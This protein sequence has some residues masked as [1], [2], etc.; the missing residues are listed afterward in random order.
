MCIAN[1][2][3]SGAVTF[4]DWRPVGAIEYGYVAPD[5]LDPDV[6]FGAGRNVVTRYRYST[7]QTENVSPIPVL[8]D[9]YRVNRTQ[10][11]LFSAAD[12]HVL[13]YAANVVFETRDGGAT[14]RAI[15]PDLAGEKPGIPASLGTLADDDP[16]AAKKRGAVYALGPSFH[17]T[18]TLWAG[19]DDGLIHVTRDGGESWQDVTPDGLTPWS[20]V[21]QIEASH[22][23]DESAYASVSRLRV[24]D[25]A[26]Y[27]YRTHDGGASWQLV[28]GRAAGGRVRSTRCAR[29]PVRQGLLYAGTET[30][31]WVSFDDGDHWQSLQM[32]LPHSSMRDLWIH[33]DDLIV[34]THGRG[35]WILDDLAP[36]RQANAAVA[37]AAMHLFAPTPAVR[38]RRSL[39]TD[40]PLPADE[41]M[42]ENPPAGA[43]IDYV[44]GSAATRP[45]DPRD[46][47]RRRRAGAP[48]RQH[49]RAGAHRRG[50]RGADDPHLLGA[51]VAQP[52]ATPG[53]HRWVWDLRYAPPRGRRARLPDQRRAPRHAAGAAGSA[54]RAGN[55]HGAP[56]GGRRD[57]ATAPL[58]VTMDPRVPTSAR[59]PRRAARGRAHAGQAALRGHRGDALGAGGPRAARGA[60]RSRRRGGLARDLDGA[61]RAGDRRPS[62]A[63]RRRTPRPAAPG[64]ETLAGRVASL[65]DDVGQADVAPTAAQARGGGP[66]RPRPRRRARPLAE[67]RR[68]A[69]TA[70]PQAAGPR[71]RPRRPGQGPTATSPTATRSDAG[72]APPR[73]RPEQYL[74]AVVETHAGPQQQRRR[75]PGHRRS[76]AAGSAGSSESSSASRIAR[77]LP[78][79][80]TA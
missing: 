62:K 43:V 30:G 75:A 73:L 32:N 26:P 16:A 58:E 63:A 23:D 67:P 8:G 27:V 42:G 19:T 10:P 34:A 17:T 56:D 7:G 74:L 41:P 18:D 46:P 70:Q 37:G 13:Y 72:P 20:K 5:P 31:V 53:M 60:R 29:I 78:R 71:P 1:R 33:D 39:N 68:R 45:G 79:I 80:G 54:G 48:L 77:E 44:L 65:Y 40:T 11:I 3:D 2:G 52:A 59:G 47:R 36:L 50:P 28:T 64:L 9:D 4:R 15:S 22:F 24:D 66:G 76:P 51:A 38:V 12:P 57:V 35:F 61:R 69:A 55:L 49:R 14:W 21:T 6:V 25:L